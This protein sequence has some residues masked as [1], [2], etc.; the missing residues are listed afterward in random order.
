MTKTKI[1]LI[2]KQKTKMIQCAVKTKRTKKVHEI[3]IYLSLI[4]HRMDLP[5]LIT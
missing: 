3:F 2:Y 5:Q 1:Y 4:L